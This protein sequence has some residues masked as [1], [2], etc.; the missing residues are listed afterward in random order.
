[1]A[2]GL[3]LEASAASWASRTR[4]AEVVRCAIALRARGALG[5]IRARAAERRVLELIDV[6]R[7][8]QRSRVACDLALT[9]SHGVLSHDTRL[10]HAWCWPRRPAPDHGDD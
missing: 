10:V 5:V 8:Q 4:A 6:I 2:H 1:V 9:D 3:T 7:R